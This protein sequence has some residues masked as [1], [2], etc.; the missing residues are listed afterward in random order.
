MKIIINF[1]IIAFMFSC[2]ALS[3]TELKMGGTEWPPYI[4]SK[5]PNHG[6]AAEIVSQIFE[7]AGHS[8]E[9]FFFPW[10]RTQHL[11]TTGELDGL[12]VA[13]YT[14]E[15]SKTMGY[16]IPYVNTAIVLIKR[17]SDPFIFN[18]L[19]DLEGKKIGVLGGYGYL[20]KIESEKIQKSFVNSFKQNL[21]KLVNQRIDL[22]LEENLNARKIISLMPK[23]IQD[24]VTII[25]NPFEVKELHITLSKNVPNYERILEDFNIALRAMIQD[26]SYQRMLNRFTYKP[27]PIDKKHVSESP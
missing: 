10:K 27:L 17:K 11:V 25:E 23:K 13:W 1:I 22:T 2:N 14:E 18:R 8:V 6:I 9:F 26:G 24:S 21:H 12:A 3:A 15:R 7:R 19:E 16:S 4:G 20:K 5:L